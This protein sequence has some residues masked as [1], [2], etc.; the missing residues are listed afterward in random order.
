M[1]LSLDG[2][3]MGPEEGLAVDFA[4]HECGGSARGDETGIGDTDETENTAQVRL[5]KSK[6]AM[7]VP[8]L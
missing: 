6:E 3:E 4:L 5:T 2:F 7:A 8:A 1:E